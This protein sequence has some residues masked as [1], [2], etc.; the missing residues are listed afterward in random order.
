MEGLAEGIVDEEK[1]KVDIEMKSL[2]DILQGDALF[3]TY[4]DNSRMKQQSAFRLPD[5][6][7]GLQP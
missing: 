1:T 4:D 6:F 7:V 5:I 2:A 3:Q